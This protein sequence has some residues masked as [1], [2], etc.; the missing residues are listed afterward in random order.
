MSVN[1][2]DD[3]VDKSAPT[4]GGEGQDECAGEVPAESE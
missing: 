3:G 4:C 2:S 1:N